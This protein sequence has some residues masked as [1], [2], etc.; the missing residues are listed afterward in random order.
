MPVFDVIIAG[1]GASGLMCAA[2]CAQKGLSCA[3]V[4]KNKRCG[5]KLSITGKGRCNVTNNSDNDNILRNIPR[6]PRFMYSALERFSSYDTMNFF[7]K[8]GVPLKTERGNR[9]FPVSDKASDIVDALVNECK[10]QGVQF[11]NDEVLSVLTENGRAVGLVCKNGSCKAENVILAC[12]GRSYP[13][14][15]SNGS[16]YEIAKKIGH[17]VME[18]GPSLCPIECTEHEE[19]ADTMGLSLRNCTLSLYAEGKKKPVYS[20]LGELIFTHFGLSG[21]LVLSASAHMGDLKKNNYTLRID[22]KPAL[23]DCTLDKRIVRDLT[24]LANKEMSNALRK[25]LPQKI[26][27][28]VLKRSG[29]APERR[30]NSITKEERRALLRTLKSLTFSVSRLRP[31]DE[32]IITRGGVAVKEIDPS[33]MRSKLCEGLYIVGEMLDVDAYTGGYNLQIAFSTANAAADS[34]NK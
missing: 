34:I 22:L 10:R 26:I 25:L 2:R 27:P 17:S 33:T 24:D 20:E 8:L 6:N 23:D 30:A 16:G 7:E 1:G 18:I 4:E 19:C 15:G 21:P 12:G 14:T 13:K 29:I 11:I 32:A 28:L 5:V 3:V 31:I 9:V